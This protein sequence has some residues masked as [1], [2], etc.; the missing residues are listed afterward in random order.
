MLVILT[1]SCCFLKYQQIHSQPEKLKFQLF[2]CRSEKYYAVVNCILKID[3]QFIKKK[4]LRLFLLVEQ[5]TNVSQL[6]YSCLNVVQGCRVGISIP[7]SMHQ[8]DNAFSVDCKFKV[9]LML[10]YF[11]Q[12]NDSIFDF[13]NIKIDLILQQLLIDNM[14]PIRLSILYGFQCLFLFPQFIARVE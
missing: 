1:G 12:F 7:I 4:H 6:R 8:F 2:S 11:N 5:W 14:V 9:I 13:K 3:E 10:E